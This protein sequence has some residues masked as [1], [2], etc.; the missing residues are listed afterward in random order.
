MNDYNIIIKDFLAFI[1]NERGYSKNTI[2][3]YKND[4]KKFM[5]FIKNYNFNMLSDLSLIDI[6][7]IR[8]FLGKEVENGKTF[9]TVARRLATIKSFFNYLVTTKII[10]NNPSTHIRTPKLEK[11]IPYYVQQ[12]KIDY[13]MNLPDKTTLIG[14]RDK[15]ILELF[16]ATGIRLSELARLN[17]ESINRYENTLRVMGKGN[18]ERLV[19]FSNTAKDAL[20]RYIKQRKISW[21]SQPDTPLFLGRGTNRISVRTIQ[22]RIQIYLKIVLGGVEGA[23]P[24]TLRHTF[25]VHLLDNDADIRS[26]QELLGHSS[27]SSTQIYT[28]LNP[29]KI[30]EVY[31]QKH[32][33]GS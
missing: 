1:D 12:D 4:L 16:Y 29:E 19:P 3:G 13:L 5:N 18:K 33:H 24:H 27:I 26:I 28:K 21:K 9:K 23:S 10:S 25:G 7:A 2:L 31:K 22:K 6:K 17:I 15:A 20:D 30:K 14:I 8:H 11:K 32:P